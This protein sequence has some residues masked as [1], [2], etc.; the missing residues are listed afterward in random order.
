MK[1]ILHIAIAA[2]LLFSNSICSQTAVNDTTTRNP[3]DNLIMR[4]VAHELLFP[5]ERVYLHFDNNCY[6]LTD[7]MWFKA[8]VTSGTENEPTKFSKVLYVELVAPEGYVVRTNKYPI[9]EDGSCNGNFELN[10]LL[11][12][13]YYEVRAYTRYMLNW[14]DEAIFSRVFPVFDKVRNCDWS[15]RNML[16]RRR[17]FLIDVEKDSTV[18]GLDRKTE[19]LNGQLPEY[20]LKFFPESGHLV[21][22]IEST[23]AYEV[24]GNDGVNISDSITILS[25]GD[26]L[27]TSVPSHMGKGTFRFTPESGTKY[28]AILHTG[29]GNEKFKLPEVEEEGAVISVDNSNSGITGISIKNNLDL[30]CELGC[31]ILHRGAPLFY[32]RFPSDSRNMLFAIE[33][34]RLAEGV[35]RVVLFVSDSIPLAERQFFVTHDSIAA[36]D[37]E[38]ARLVVS[39]PKE[40]PQP[41]GKVSFS[42]ERE[43][44]KPIEGN[45]FSLA[46][47]DAANNITTSYDYNIYTYML[48]GSELKGY[49]PNAAQYFDQSNPHRRDE[50]DLI[51][52]TH[53]WTSY[54]WDKLAKR[55]V[56]LDQP[57]EKG[58]TIKGRFVKKT[59]DKRFGHLDRLN[60]TNRPN[61]PV[62]FFIAYNDS[63]ITEYSFKTDMRGEFR[64]QSD[65]F[66]GKRIARLTPR[67]ACTSPD[68]S[69]FVFALDRYFS[70]QMRFY[71][72]WERTPGR[73]MTAEERSEEQAEAIRVKPFEYLLSQVE[74][75]SRNKRDSHY[76][77]P[78]SEIRLDFLDEWEY[79]QDVTYFN[80]KKSGWGYALERE[81]A[82]FNRTDFSYT[83]EMNYNPSLSSMDRYYISKLNHSYHVVRPAFTKGQMNSFRRGF[84]SLDNDGYLLS[85]PSYKNS[86]NAADILR[87]AFWRH[88][89]N[90]CY[91][92]QSMVVEGE[93]SPYS[94]PVPDYEYLKGVEP[95]KMMN[96]NE[97]VIRSDEG[98]R[99][100]FYKMKE[101]YKRYRIGAFDY[102]DHYDSF[103]NRMPIGARNGDIDDAP[104]AVTMFSQEQ[105]RELRNMDKP[106]YVA[107]FIPYGNQPIIPALAFSSTTRYTMVYGYTESKEFYSPDYS[108]I[109]PDSIAADY[110]RTLLWT[111]R[112]DVT[113]GRIEV[114]FYNNSNAEEFNISIEGFSN[115]TFYSNAPGF[116]T[117][118]LSEEEERRLDIDRK[119]KHLD[120]LSTPELLI[121]CFRNDEEG[122]RMYNAGKYEEAFALFY[123]A[124]TF[125]Y[126]SAT[127]N[128]GV[129]YMT[130][131]GTE[132]NIE[133]GFRY[134]RKAA[135]LGVDKALH[136]LA[137]CYFY[138]LGTAQNDSLAMKYYTLS[139]EKGY[140][141]SQTMLAHCYL[142]GKGVEKDS[143]KAYEWFTIAAD[144]GEPVAQYRTAE[145]LAASDSVAGLS[146]RQMRRQPAIE[147]YKKSAD[148]GNAYAQYRLAQ[149][150]DTGYYV[151]KSR[152]KAFHWY[153]RAA[154]QGHPQA[155]EQVARCYEKGRGTKKN[156]KKA[157]NWYRLARE[158]G[159]KLAKE[160]MEWY[161][162]FHFFD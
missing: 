66:T 92:I 47:T 97:I 90:W 23:V 136:N 94:I 139:A 108:A 118:E 150:Y 64:I 121:Q 31:V 96:F 24:F 13:G 9:G 153:M 73:A 130:G 60:I 3:L 20:D 50:L 123:E 62:S 40:K 102:S 38:T 29:E 56:S 78:R 72:Y 80:N 122:R 65:D 138:G 59:P 86:L 41:H 19:W 140:P 103:T 46:V 107:C 84:N 134:L 69:I 161:D 132:Q 152:K 28:R 35:N 162:I 109:H 158:Q 32:E 110:R 126:P 14:G 67:I 10:E 133:E 42:I 148:G 149:F 95:A 61:T 48:L 104:D 26:V 127:F 16:D 77:P 124:A 33:N 4:S 137:T 49:I 5:Q 112:T 144:N 91:W 142:T 100:L 17:A 81:E 63:T 159:S 160:K 143:V 45:N 37:M 88:N 82:F 99:D 85:D 156:D 98:T 18:T 114:E 15:F 1:R 128:T 51:M 55:N 70:P 135:N 53:G 131:N 93:Y 58:I 119:S 43:D 54:N 11:L 6:F 34:S 146:K 25:D 113:D 39:S 7:N 154:N 105:T 68:D 145:H 30:K 87:S 141:T 74:V 89:L 75:V 120:G 22:G 117:R 21:N 116:A 115:G 57:I 52:L 155:I 147:Y 76:R 79:A 125:G 36:G 101:S 27:L 71:D 8:Y 106:N 2:M 111:P 157:A 12:S 151:K 83:P 129:C 44:G